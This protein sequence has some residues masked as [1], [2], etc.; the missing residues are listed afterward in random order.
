MHV[1]LEGL[2]SITA[3]LFNFFVRESIPNMDSSVDESPASGI[4]SRDWFRECMTW[5][6]Q[7]G[8]GCL[9]N[10]SYKAEEASPSGVTGTSWCG[11]CR[12]QL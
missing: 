5:H 4:S 12:A 8:V 10:Q 7:T 3:D 1:T 2:R 11:S 9:C 6:G